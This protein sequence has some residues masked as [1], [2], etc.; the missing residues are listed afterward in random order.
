MRKKTLEFMYVAEAHGFHEQRFNFSTKEKFDVRKDNKGDLILKKKIHDEKLPDDFWG[1][2][3]LG[4]HLFVGENGSGKTTVMRLICQWICH[5]SEKKYPIETGILVFRE[6][7][8]LKY[9]AF[10]E[11]KEMEI[12]ADIP[13]LS[14]NQITDFFNDI[15]LIYYSNT[16]TELKIDGYDILCD[17]SIPSKMKK[18]NANGQSV[19][20]DVMA[21]YKSY[22]FGRQIKAALSDDN[23]PIDYIS[24]E[25]QSINSDEIKDLLINHYKDLHKELKEIVECKLMNHNGKDISDTEFF[26]TKLIHAIFIG[27]IIKLLKWGRKYVH[28]GRNVVE[29]TIC[30]IYRLNEKVIVSDDFRQRKVKRLEDFLK[31]LFDGCYN[32]YKDSIYK[33]DYKKY[34]SD[35][36]IKVKD[37][38]DFITNENNDKYLGSWIIGSVTVKTGKKRY[39]WKIN[40]KNYK[41]NYKKFWNVYNKINIQIENIYLSWDASSGEQSWAGLFTDLV[42]DEVDENKLNIWYFLDEPDNTFHPEWKRKLINNI[43]SEL[44]KR[45]GKKQIWISTHSPIMLSDM[46][47]QA[48]IYL[49]KSMIGDKEVDEKEKLTFAQNIYVLFE[50]AFFLSDGVIGEFASKKIIQVVKGIEEIEKSLFDIKKKQ[51][52]NES[53]KLNEICKKIDNYQKIIN[54]V[55]EPLFKNQMVHYVNSCRKMIRQVRQIDKNKHK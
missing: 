12:C 29:D 6:D 25:I 33:Y 14:I 21:N 34:W 7:N 41:E 23:F 51:N 55:A 36:N 11:G 53:N 43:I 18:A 40:L 20:D 30:E 47:G 54:M 13:K 37:V 1:S 3:I 45:Y 19:G 16:M 28:N 2:D 38:M 39:V 26:K 27:I 22:E 49:K 4:L 15:R 17:Y 52:I 32:K 50:D 46:P 24:L 44:E 10:S 9:V 5:L 31:E 42:N 8:D 35:V 48:A